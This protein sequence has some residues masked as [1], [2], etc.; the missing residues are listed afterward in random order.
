MISNKMT[1]VFIKTNGASIKG[2]HENQPSRR[3]YSLDS[4]K[5]EHF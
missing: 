5:Q 1:T 3:M 2:E 4:V